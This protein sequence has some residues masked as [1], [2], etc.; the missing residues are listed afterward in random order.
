MPKFP[1]PVCGDPNGFLFWIDKEPP[2]RCPEDYTHDQ[3]IT[4]AQH[5]P[6]QQKRALSETIRRRCAPDCFDDAGRI[7]P[8]TIGEALTRTEAA[9]FD[10]MSGRPLLTAAEWNSYVARHSLFTGDAAQEATSRALSRPRDNDDDGEP[11]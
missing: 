10:P 5:C 4:D 2:D 3:G 9:G 1:C 8:G 7:L 11:E 6:M